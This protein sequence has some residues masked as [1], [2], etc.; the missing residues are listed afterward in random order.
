MIKNFTIDNIKFIV[1]IT[2]IKPDTAEE[3][4]DLKVY[5]DFPE[6]KDIIP[7]FLGADI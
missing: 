2:D 3:Y 1:T 6:L 4:N 5:K 7:E